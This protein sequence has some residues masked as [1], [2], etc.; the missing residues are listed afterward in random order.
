[1]DRSIEE[2][3]SYLAPFLKGGA[4]VVL[5]LYASLSFAPMIDFAYDDNGTSLLANI[6]FTITSAPALA[7]VYL[8]ALFLAKRPQRA[9]VN[10]WV[11]NRLGGLALLSALWIMFY[12][13]AV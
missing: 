11:L 8:A 5:F 2:P 13:L 6:F 4:I 9:V 12:T 10:A 3:T 1:M 7:S